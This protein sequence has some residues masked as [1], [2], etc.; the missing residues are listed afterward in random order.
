[1]TTIA[2]HI[3]IFD[4]EPTDDLVTKR[5]VAI[6]QIS[7]ALKKQTSVDELLQT[8]NDLARAVEHKGVFSETL[9]KEIEEAIAK[10]AV[11]FVAEKNGTQMVTCG[12][13]GALQA[14][15]AN[16]GN[17]S[18]LLIS[19]VLALGLW[20]AL[21]FQKP[22]TNAKL[23]ALR[24]ELLNKAHGV[25]LKR[26]S[27]SRKRMDVPDM[28]FAAPADGSE[29]VSVDTSFADATR[30]TVEALRANAAVDR[31]ELDLLWWVLSDRSELLKRHLSTEKNSTTRA[32]ASGIEAGHLLRRMPSEAHLHLV[33][34]NV[35]ADDATSSLTDVIKAVADDRQA[36][37]A[38]YGGQQIV[39]ACPAVFPL[40]NGLR[41]G[42]SS[43]GHAKQKR[44]LEDWAARALL[45]SSILQVT[46]HLPKVAV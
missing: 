37:V 22:S 30:A 3:R 32:I 18:N 28:K 2:T 38:P 34:R 24:T 4:A 25:V 12:M 45:E 8:A 39:L 10:S 20:S 40:L 42:T 26:A 14:I 23:E 6:G 15:D 11:S 43:D 35:G 19:D 21:G 29:P 41:N 46:S 1:M 16:P 36:L 27:L 9:G 13:L 17:S 31:E 7:E 5:T 33:L 44:S